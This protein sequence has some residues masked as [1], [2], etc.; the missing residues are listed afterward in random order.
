[1]SREPFP[2]I[3]ARG[4]ERE[5]SLL[6]RLLQAVWAGGW[7]D[8]G[9]FSTVEEARTEL[10]R[11]WPFS[12]KC[13]RAYRPDDLAAARIL[14]AAEYDA[15]QLAGHSEFP[16]THRFYLAVRSDLIDRAWAAGMKGGFGVHL[17]RA[18]ISM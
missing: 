5:D 15:I 11:I 16:T 6:C 18:S 8:G 7:L 9:E 3:L 2:R 17:S 12:R 14:N 13:D 4:H 10:A 1:M